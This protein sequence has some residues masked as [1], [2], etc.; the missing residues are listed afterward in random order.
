M[1][2]S[3]SAQEAS[4]SPS[5]AVSAAID[6]STSPL[7]PPPQ[8]RTQ[9]PLPV[10]KTTLFLVSRPAS[11]ELEK[12]LATAPRDQLFKHPE[13]DLEAGP[14]GMSFA[15][16]VAKRGNQL[17][18]QSYAVRYGRKGARI[19]SVSPRVIMTKMGKE[20]LEGPCGVMIQGMVDGSAVG[21]VGTPEEVVD[22]VAFL[23]SRQSSLIAGTDILVDGGT[24]TSVNSGSSCVVRCNENHTIYSH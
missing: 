2:S 6:T 14:E 16:T 10:P 20:S 15:Y 8:S 11:P 18:V 5:L 21:R 12:H 17:S 1:S 13:I 9:N 19:N 3:S 24:I 7:T 4:V 23:A 22:M